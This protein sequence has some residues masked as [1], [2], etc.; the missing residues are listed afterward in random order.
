M[1]KY[2]VGLVILFTIV[3]TIY[4]SLT[5]LLFRFIDP[6]TT[7]FI[8]QRN[9]SSFSNIIYPN[10]VVQYWVPI[11]SIS[12]NI[13]FAT[14][15]SEDQRFIEHFG[16]DFVEVEKV[17]ESKIDG[18]KLRGA[19]TIT[20]QTAKNLFLFP[21]KLFIRKGI[22]VYYSVV[23]ELLWSKKRIL[24]VYLNI[25]QFGENIFGVEAASKYYFNKPS[26]YLS[27]NEAAQLVAILPNPIKLDLNKK[28]LYLKN[29]I[30]RIE[31]TINY[32]DKNEII[33]MVNK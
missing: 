7:A 19:S 10:S 25:A 11:K 18:R 16:V 22:E 4:T 28:S 27:I 14:I 23:M 2:S 3:L 24:E 20:Q 17:I 26:Q 33:K 29:R 8:Q 12:K 30:V 9:S 13:I 5:L 32:I 1:L 21:Q 31:K 15:A 6:P